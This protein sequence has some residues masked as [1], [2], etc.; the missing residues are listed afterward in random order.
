MAEFPDGRFAGL[1]LASPEVAVERYLMTT[2]L[3]FIRAM[4]VIAS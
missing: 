4:T 2:E 1:P 3:D